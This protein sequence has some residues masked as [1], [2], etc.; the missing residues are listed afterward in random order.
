MVPMQIVV[1]VAAVIGVILRAFVPGFPL[2]DA[3]I[4]QIAVLLLGLFGVVVQARYGFAATGT[5]GW[6]KSKAF[7]L[8]VAALINLVL[9][10]YVPEFPLLEADIAALI[11]WGL[12]QFGINPEIRAKLRNIQ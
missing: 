11:V 9:H 8:G 2:D 6:L 5:D 10:S 7:W 3:Q 12:S 1:A 4:V